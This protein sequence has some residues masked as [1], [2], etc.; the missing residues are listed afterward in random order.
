MLLHG[1]IA[2]L[3][4]LLTGMVSI[5]P[6]LNGM[7]MTKYRKKPVVIEATQWVGHRKYDGVTPSVEM[8]MPPA[9]HY[10][11]REKGWFQKKRWQI[12]TLEGWLNI[13]PDDWI[14]TGVKGE[15]YPCK[16]DIFEQTYEL[17]ETANG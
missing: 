5:Y 4:A 1:L 15:F 7:M 9:P 11:L 6:V 3:T 14:I 8:P 10:L 16:P 13:S 2:V 17:V 12:R